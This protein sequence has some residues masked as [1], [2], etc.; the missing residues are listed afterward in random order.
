[1]SEQFIKIYDWM[2]DLDL[3][4]TEFLVFALI[5]SLTESTGGCL[6]QKYIQDRLHI[7]K[8]WAINSIVRLREKGYIKAESTG[9]CYRPKRYVA[10]VN[11]SSVL[12]CSAV[13]HSSAPTEVN[14]SAPTEVN[15]STPHLYIDKNTYKNTHKNTHSDFERFF[16]ELS[17]DSSPDLIEAVRAFQEHRKKLKKPMTDRALKLNLKKARDLSDGTTKGIIELLDLA[18]EKGWQGV[19]LPK[20]DRYEQESDEDFF[21]GID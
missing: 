10:V 9:N 17:I 21:A 15:S 20:E 3:N 1:M 7:S 11:S 2:Y 12:N 19:Y 5:Y 6:G 16:A 18:I 14:S 8:R 13:L 4:K